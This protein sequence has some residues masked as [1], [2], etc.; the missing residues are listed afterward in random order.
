VI[1]GFGTIAAGAALLMTSGYLISRAAQRPDILTLTAAIVGVRAFAISRAVL[2]YG[3]RLTSH[4]AALRMLGR[5]RARFFRAIAPRVPGEVGSGDL[6]SRFVGDVDT[7]QDLYVRALAPPLVAALVICGATLAAWLLLPQAAPVVFAC[8][9]IAAAAVPALAARLAAQAG[10]RQG[11]ERAALTTELVET[12]AGAPEL[13]VAGRGDERVEQLGEAD[14]RLVR[15]ARRDA[16]A[17]AATTALGSLVAGLS[18][19]AVL[20]VAIPAVHAGTFAG[21]LVAALAFLVLGAFEGVTPLAPA[22]RRLHECAQAARRLEALTASEPLVQDPAEPLPLPPSG[23][24]LVEDVRARYGPDEPWVLD[25]AQ[26]T[27]AAGGRVALLGPSGAGKTT[28]AHLLA[29]FRDPDRGRVLLGGVDVRLAAQEDVRTAVTLGAQDAHLFNTTIREN[30]LMARRDAGEEELW[31][32]LAAVGAD[33]VTDLDTLVGEH[34]G[35][36]SGGQRRR[37]ALARTLLA[38]ARFLVLDEP[39]AHLGA[40][41]AERA[42]DGIFELA[43]ERG[44][45]VITHRRE[46]LERFDAVLE[47]RDGRIEALHA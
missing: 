11:A 30:L 4:D 7:L 29:R 2:R 42:I 22:A 16:F 39:T 45:L 35:L 46:N 34:G 15:L 17:G 5:L 31:A 14:A 23:D 25:G 44:V 33:W 40:Q 47:L 9:L 43:G 13:A 27:L 6:L 41:D 8:L 21:V 28:L 36:L 26:L 19:I 18:V 1:L 32:A 12:I 37:L 20:L 38:P 24:L 3:E 10:R